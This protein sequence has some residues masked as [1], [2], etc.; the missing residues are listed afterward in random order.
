[1]HAQTR[2]S[3]FLA[4]A[5][6]GAACGGAAVDTTTDGGAPGSIPDSGTPG[7]GG[8]AL[9]TSTAAT[10]TVTN[11]CAVLKRD[12]SACQTARAAK[13]LA[14]VWLKFSCRVTLTSASGMITATSDGQPDYK[15]FYFATS[16]ACYEAWP[17]GIHNPNSIDAQSYSV[18]FPT[19]P[20]TTATSMGGNGLIGLALNGVPLYANFAAPGDDIYREAVSF[21]KCAGHPQMTGSYHY[22][23][24][25]YS[26]TYNDANLVGVLRDGYA[27]YGRKDM[28]GSTP[29][30]DAYGGHSAVTADSS[31]ASVYHYHVNMQTSTN[32][33]TAG[34]SQWFL[35]KGTWRGAPAPCATCL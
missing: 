12:T 1:M 18:N 29:T 6:F 24:E 30:L 33:G 13:G 28:D 19:A 26:L 22:H 2:A 9:S 34:Q 16:N 8:C 20:N 35:S 10:A 5:L 25:P 7:G 17:Q 14:G 32:P 15:S 23:S 21:D 4:A 11:G 27:L 3:L 31:G